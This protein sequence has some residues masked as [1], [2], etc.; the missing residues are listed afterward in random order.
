MSGPT[1]SVRVFAKSVYL[2]AWGW[3][4]SI[5]WL[6]LAGMQQHLRREGAFPPDY[7]MAIL[8]GGAATGVVIWLA[9]KWLIRKTGSAPD[10]ALQQREWHHA[11]WWAL[12]PNLMLLGTVWLMITAAA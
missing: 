10:A 8:L 12:Y 1:S 6:W 9:G 2:T 7:G 5:W 11:F 3:F 4:A